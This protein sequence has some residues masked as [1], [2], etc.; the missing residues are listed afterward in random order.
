MKQLFLFL[1]SGIILL[2]SCENTKKNTEDNPSDEK[3]GVNVT[4][5][6]NNEAVIVMPE[7]KTGEKAKPLG[8]ARDTTIQAGNENELTPEEKE[9]RLE[10]R[11]AKTAFNNGMQYYQEG[12][13]EQAIDAFK[14]VLQ[15]D[16]NNDK[17]FFNLGKIYAMQG[18]PDL[19]LSY[20]EDAVRLNP[21]D[22]ASL[23]GI[24]MY[25]YNLGDFNNAL[26]YYN[27][28]I[29]A[30]PGYAMAYYNRGTVSGQMK[31]YA[32]SL[33]DLTKA[34]ELDPN[35]DQAYM[36]RGLAYFY[37][38]KNDMACLDWKKAAEMGN[39][40]AVKAVGLY[41]TDKK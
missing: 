38:K 7:S 35:N 15:M 17:A 29:E 26:S 8:L 27:R 19:A 16:E 6:E 10:L 41:C 14:M 12:S 32:E 34:I 40:E 11:R 13:Y 24:G 1:F 33:A 4:I 22:S 36:N 2:S 3:T 37:S 39:P 28:S 21:N 20:Y 23:L 9:R 31:N 25:Y 18:Q 30:G 5:N